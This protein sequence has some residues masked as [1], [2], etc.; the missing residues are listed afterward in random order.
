MNHQSSFMRVAFVVFVVVLA[1][2]A[3]TSKAPAVREDLLAQAGFKT[4]VATT[5]IQQQHLQTLPQGTLTQMQQ[6]GK[7]Y[8]VYPDVPGKRLYVGTPKEYDAYVALR[9]R[10]GLPSP[11]ASNATTADMRDYLKQD[12]AMTK[13][14]AQDASIPS[15]AIWPDFGG[16]GWVP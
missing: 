10:N 6:T 14:D 8:Y 9:T 13:A 3:T 1:S 12:A 11:S 15:W 4:V 7:H 16:L 2:C 5:L